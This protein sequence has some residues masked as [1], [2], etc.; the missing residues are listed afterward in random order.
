MFPHVSQVPWTV[1]VTSGCPDLDR[2]STIVDV[3]QR[4]CGSGKD[5]VPVTYTTKETNLTRKRFIEIPNEEVEEVIN[6]FIVEPDW[7]KFLTIFRFTLLW[8]GERGGNRGFVNSDCIILKMYK[9]NDRHKGR[10]HIQGTLTP[11]TRHV[12]IYRVVDH[13]TRCVSSYDN[14]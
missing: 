2:P 6:Y 14:F 8:R 7:N 4:L 5:G 9:W 12:T 13:V 10:S 11:Q 3:A 1:P